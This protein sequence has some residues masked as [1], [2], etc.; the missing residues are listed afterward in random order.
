MSHF[1]SESLAN[2]ATSDPEFYQY[3]HD[4]DHQLLEFDD[5]EHDETGHSVSERYLIVINE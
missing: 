1:F 2:L 3:L 5:S 4:N